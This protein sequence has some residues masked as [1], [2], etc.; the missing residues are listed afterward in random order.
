MKK[1]NE[2]FLNEILK[3]PRVFGVFN[4]HNVMKYINRME[5]MSNQMREYLVAYM[6]VESEEA[7]KRLEETYFSNMTVSQKKSF[8]NEL[9]VCMENDLNHYRQPA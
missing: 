9:F 3:K 2:D 5:P 6:T 1:E 8:E 7:L 4:K